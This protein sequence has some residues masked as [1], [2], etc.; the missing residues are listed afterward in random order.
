IELALVDGRKRAAARAYQ[1]AAQRLGPIAIVDGEE[2]HQDGVV[3]ASRGIDAH[4]LL[5]PLRKA[6]QHLLELEKEFTVAVEEPQT[7]LAA[8]AV[9]PR[10]LRQA[11]PR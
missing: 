6:N 10:N 11:H 1:R 5:V 9:R 3:R 7:E 4:L 8:H 2:L